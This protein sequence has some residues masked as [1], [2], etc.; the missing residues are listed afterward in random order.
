MSMLI[1]HFRSFLKANVVERNRHA[2]K[3]QHRNSYSTIFQYESLRITLPF[4]NV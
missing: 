1:D 3:G 4:R 2:V